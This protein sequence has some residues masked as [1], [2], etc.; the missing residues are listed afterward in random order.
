VGLVV[1]LVQA[2]VLLGYA[3]LEAASVSA[4]RATMGVTTA[5]FFAVTAAGLAACAG[6]VYRGRSWGRSPLVLAQLITLGLAWS[7]RGGSTTWVAV[8]LLVAALVALVGVLH[9]ASIAWLERG[10]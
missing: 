1:V 9:P 10:D 8:V 3:V 4:A 7:F 5:L 2:T 6:A